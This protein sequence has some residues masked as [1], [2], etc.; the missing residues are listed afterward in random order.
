MQIYNVLMDSKTSFLLYIHTSNRARFYKV[1]I[2]DNKTE[3]H[4]IPSL[5]AIYVSLSTLLVVC[6]Y[7]YTSILLIHL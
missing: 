4:A 1:F 3:P 5:S 2:P 6:I 7:V